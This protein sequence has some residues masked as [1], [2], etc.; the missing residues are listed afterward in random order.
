MIT[1]PIQTQR[2]LLTWQSPFGGSGSRN[3]Y[4]VGELLADGSSVRFTYLTDSDS[5][6]AAQA[7]GFD[8]YPGL[9]LGAS[10][11]E[12][13]LQI[14]R[15]RLP[16]T[17]RDDF[18]NFLMT[19]GLSPSAHFSDLSL[20]AYTGARLASDS[21]GVTET[22]DGFD[23]PFEFIFDIAGFRHHLNN[24]EDLKGGDPVRLVAD[25]TNKHD[26]NA[27]CVVR[28][29][30]RRLGF[31]NRLQAERVLEWMHANAIRTEIFRLNG[32]PQYPRLFILVRI[33]PSRLAAAA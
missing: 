17:D 3:R 32:R 6:R 23:R 31:I 27:V 2:A 5:F 19:F 1:D 29:G 12:D 4:A 21:F 18:K 22:F 24:I 16:Q 28:D 25:P 15:R 7:E 8:G 10:L 33:Q 20:L 9:P 14:L 26:S 11:H 13:A 30:E